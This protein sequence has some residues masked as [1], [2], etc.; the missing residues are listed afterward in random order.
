MFTDADVA[1]PIIAHGY[2][3][4]LRDWLTS[5]IDPFIRWLT[6]GQWR[7][8]DAPWEGF[9]SETTAEEERRDREWFMRQLQ[10]GDKSWFKNRAVIATPDNVPIGWVNRYGE[11]DN[12]HACFVGID[13]CEDAYLNRGLGT[14]ALQLWVDHIFS[15]S[16]VHKIGLETWSFNPRMIRVAERAGFVCEGCQREIRQ[17]QGEWLDLVQFGILREEWQKKM[18]VEDAEEPENMAA[19]F[20]AR[21]AG[22]DGHMRD[23]IFSGTMFTQFYQAVSSPIEKTDEP[24]H[25]LDLGCGTGLEIEALFQ[26]VPNASITG[27]DL[28]K[29]MLEQL[30]KR[31]AAHM[32]QITLVTDS[33]L[34]MPLGTQAYDYV[35]STM[36]VHHVLHDTK[37][38][39]YM[40]IHAA[41][42]P[43]G[44]Y[45][46]GDSVIPAVM[47]RQ[48]LAEYHE[49]V[50][51]M[52]QAQDGQYHIDIPFSIE[53]QRSLLLEAGFKD[54]QVVWQKDSNVVWNVAVYVVTA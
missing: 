10:G 7:L 5:D 12:P 30:R 4:I 23:N 28:S 9:R 24:L 48:F 49:Q 42:K 40:K 15:T 20:D 11:K 39:L 38:E 21:A 17:W 3:T 1:V 45:I 43:G 2:L 8:L 51:G 19:F 54:F 18:G 34:T 44:K 26:R 53:T 16:D 22:Y 47:E 13:I 6:Q 36:A 46:E 31:Y 52:P 32:N 33:Y 25:I 27:V 37:R 29:N 41:L 35:I 14:E 50:A